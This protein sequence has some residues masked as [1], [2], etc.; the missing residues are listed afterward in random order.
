[1]KNFITEGNFKLADAE[2]LLIVRALGQYKTKDQAAKALG[3]SRATLYRKIKQY[4]I[5][6][7]AAGAT[8]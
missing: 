8:L 4:D 3:I 5:T 7:S 2:K 1:M 6:K